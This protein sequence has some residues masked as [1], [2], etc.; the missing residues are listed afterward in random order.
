MQDDDTENRDP[1]THTHCAVSAADGKGDR[2][3]RL[4]RLADSLGTRTIVDVDPLARRVVVAAF[5]QPSK[6]L[7][8]RPPTTA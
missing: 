7:S 4:P 5:E 1:T 6:T 8:I 3:S 2:A